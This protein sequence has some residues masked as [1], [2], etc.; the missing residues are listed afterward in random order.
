M[1]QLT[2]DEPQNL[3]DFTDDHYAQAGFFWN[4]LLRAREI[5]VNGKRVDRDC[6]LQVGD[7][8]TYYL[9]PKQENKP[10]FY[11][12]YEDDDILVVDKESGVNSAAV[13]A[14][15]LR[16][17]E[18]YFIHRLDRNTKGLLVFA[19][20]VSAEDVLLSAFKEHRIEKKYHALCLG[21]PPKQADM[22]TAY[23]KKDATRSFVK[24]AA[25]PIGG[26][27]KIVTEYRVLA[28]E[29]GLTKLEVTLHTGKT[30]QI[31]AHLAYIGCPVVGD[32]KYGD[33]G[34]NKV[35]KTARQCLVAKTL[36]FSLEGRF[37]YLNEKNF[38]S[39]FEAVIE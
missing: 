26:G 20:T 7:V 19:K 38:Q 13:F 30:H 2:V 18:V 14:A 15:L 37:A 21:T 27:E 3:K 6:P 11:T 33:E 24:V 22:L 39:R 9:T 36:S 12:V 23:L 25:T 8:V 29:G 16:R 28:T 1:L 4:A 10:A 5:K 34:K 32:M 17:E 35:L 31:R